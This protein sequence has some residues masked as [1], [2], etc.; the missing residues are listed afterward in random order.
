MIMLVR[1]ESIELA[2]SFIIFTAILSGSVAFLWFK[3]L[4][5]LLIYP[6]LAALILK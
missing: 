4:I 1:W 2:A 6:I 5:I 3:P